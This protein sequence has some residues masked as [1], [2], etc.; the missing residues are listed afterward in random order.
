MSL[1]TTL[2]DII[3][4]LRQGRF[5]NEQAVSQGIVLRVLQELGWDIYNTTSVWPEFQTDEGRADFALCH[6]PSRPGEFIEGK[7]P[8][9]KYPSRSRCYQA[10]AASRIQPHRVL[11]RN[12]LHE[13]SIVR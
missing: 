3:A 11:Q 4:R 8:A 5:P 10:C 13:A 6:P 12:F 2:A 9:T 7:P 1:E